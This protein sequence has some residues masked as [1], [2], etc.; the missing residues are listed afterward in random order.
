M[1]NA[2][3]NCGHPVEDH[4]EFVDNDAVAQRGMSERRHCL[5]GVAFV[6]RTDHR[7]SMFVSSDPRLC[8][9]EKFEPEKL[10]GKAKR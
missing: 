6:K 3:A 2:C 5:H 7:G 10:N 1:T 4:S 9:C 8:D